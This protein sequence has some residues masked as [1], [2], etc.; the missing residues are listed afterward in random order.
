MDAPCASSTHPVVQHLRRSFRLL[1]A[2]LV[3][4]VTIRVTVALTVTLALAVV[5]THHC[6]CYSLPGRCA[7]LVEQ[8]AAP[9]RPQGDV[10]C[11]GARQ[12]LAP[13]RP[14]RNGHGLAR[15][16]RDLQWLSPRFFQRGHGIVTN[17]SL[18]VYDLLVRWRIR[19]SCLCNQIAQSQL[20]AAALVALAEIRAPVEAEGLPHVVATQAL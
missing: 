6:H 20:C 2:N 8:E 11:A 15:V 4:Q 9:L 12:P 17:D 10:S 7:I 3:L 19:G 16:V 1:V 14:E 18:L 5:V 13:W